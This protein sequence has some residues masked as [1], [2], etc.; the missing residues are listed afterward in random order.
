MKQLTI[1]VILIFVGLMDINAQNP[2]PLLKKYQYDTNNNEIDFKNEL[3][4][5]HED[6]SYT[7]IFF[8]YYKNHSYNDTFN[9]NKIML[10]RINYEYLIQITLTDSSESEYI[11]PIKSGEKV[12]NKRVYIAKEKN[13][14]LT[15]VKL[16]RK[17]YK[18]SITDSTVSFEL[19]KE[20]LSTNDIIRIY[21]KTESQNFDSIWIP[22]VYTKSNILRYVS[23]S[24]PEIFKFNLI[25]EY[26]EIIESNKSDDMQLKQF[27]YDVSRLVE[28]INVSNVTYKWKQINYNHDLF[29][30]LL[31]IN[32]PARIGTSVEEI[33]QN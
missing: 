25:T 13:G 33:I 20:I 30:P 7:N 14:K 18:S 12:V 5:N 6:L 26:L 15:Q 23:L 8:R 4:Q 27:S 11:F 16:K 28:D 24:L 31:S 22:Q 32:L 29:L 19:N 3:S 9:P 2:L 10:F 17:L 21:W 1:L